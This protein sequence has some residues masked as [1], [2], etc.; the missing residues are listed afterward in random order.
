MSTISDSSQEAS[1]AAISS[2]ITPASSPNIFL[3]NDIPDL[4]QTNL[5]SNSPDIHKPNPS[6]IDQAQKRRSSSRSIK[7]KKFDDELVESS[8]I[9]SSRA[10]PQNASFPI[11]PPIA[12]LSSPNVAASPSS[13]TTSNQVQ[14]EGSPVLSLEKRKSRPA[15][16]RIK[17][18][19]SNQAHLNKDVSRWKPTDDLMLILSV[20]QTNDLETVHRGV[21]FS[22]KFSLREVQERWYAL[23]YNVTISKAAMFAIKQLNLEVIAQIQSKVLFSTEEEKL[24]ASVPVDKSSLE[25]FQELLN[26]N[27]SVFLPSRTAKVLH[28][29]WSLMKQYNLLQ[30]QNAQQI[31][32]MENLLT[33]SDT[34]ELID[35]SELQDAKDAV[36][37]EEI[38]GVNRKHLQEIKQLENEV[39][40]WQV[41]V[42]C[43]T[44]VSLPEFDS[45][46][47]AVLKGRIVRYLIQSREVTFGRSAKDNKVDIDLS[48]EGPAW[49]ISRRQGIIK[50]DSNGD[51][52]LINEGKKPMFIDGKP[53]L[54]GNKY[55][56]NNNSVIEITVLRF[57]F[58]VNTEALAAL[59][60]KSSG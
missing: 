55:K 29:H 20:Q 51:F 9:K 35:D 60:T 44:G 30:D 37:D 36:L 3:K 31:L 38:A 16:K 46:T 28:N 45:K 8:L 53:V 48:L 10:R 57:V 56:L 59:R 7:R 58:I 17:K 52:Y 54:I 18:P 11:L 5:F 4:Q 2:C 15:Q 49:K 23:L 14:P 40:K 27:A 1:N 22:A 39:P 21:K 32:P 24:I 34:E 42:D 26:S 50:M 41:L 12:N 19:K 47:L 43:V 13:A 6:S 25:H 33:F